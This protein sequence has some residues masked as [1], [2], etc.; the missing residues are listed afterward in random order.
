MPLGFLLD[1]KHAKR[2]TFPRSVYVNMKETSGYERERLVQFG[3]RSPRWA[4][5][6]SPFRTLAWA[7]PGFSA[8]FMYAFARNWAVDADYSVLFSTSIW[9]RG[10]AQLQSNSGFEARFGLRKYLYSDAPVGFYLGAQGV[11]L[12]NSQWADLRFGEREAL[13]DTLGS[14]ET[15]SYYDTV[16]VN[17][18]VRGIHLRMGQTVY[19]G[20]FTFDFSMG[21]GLLHRQNSMRERRGSF[22]EDDDLLTRGIYYFSMREGSFWMAGIPLHFR[23]GYTIGARPFTKSTKQNTERKFSK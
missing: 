23:L 18:K 10:I 9:Q 1:R 15:I 3:Q 13:R 2:Y 11:W 20:H 19:K 4:F 21:I 6:V 14:Y 12:E 16:L 22:E 5:F 17:R 7:D 8:G